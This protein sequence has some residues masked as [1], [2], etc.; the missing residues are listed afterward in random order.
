MDPLIIG[1]RYTLTYGGRMYRHMRYVGRGQHRPNPTTWISGPE[2]Q[3]PDGWRCLIQ[4]WRDV[5]LE[6]EQPWPEMGVVIDGTV[7]AVS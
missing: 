5:T 2:F 6:L 3:H 4:N 1:R 7:K